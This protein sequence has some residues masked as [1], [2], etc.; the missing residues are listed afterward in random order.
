M[1]GKTT[2]CYWHAFTYIRIECPGF[3]PVTFG[4]DFER[5]FFTTVQE[6]FPECFLI[7]CLFHFKQAARKK[8]KDLGIPDEEIFIAMASGVY[9][10]L[11]ILPKE[12]LL[13][14]GIP[15]VREMIIEEITNYYAEKGMS[16]SQPAF[17]ERWDK[18]W[19]YF[20]K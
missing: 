5:G 13:K 7:G 3:N 6:F 18:F 10:L 16:R 8:M 4:V 12:E 17:E 14:K 11:T 15:F 19:S 9:D 2:A 1:S 20:M